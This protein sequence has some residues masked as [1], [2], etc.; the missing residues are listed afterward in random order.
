MKSV[1]F[2]KPLNYLYAKLTGS[3][4]GFLAGTAATGLISRFFETKG[5]NNLWGLASKKRIIDKQTF[6]TIEWLISIII[7]FI[8]FEIIT[9]V[10]HKKIKENLRKYKISFYR[11]IIRNDLHSKSK[12]VLYRINQKRN[13]LLT[14]VNVSSKMA[15]ARFSKK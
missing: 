1:S 6:H 10:A 14:N 15:I 11:W 2:K 4:M 13:S 5:I 12:N 3:F 9:K 8:V 7:G